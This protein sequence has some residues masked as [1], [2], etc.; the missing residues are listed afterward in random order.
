MERL[1]KVLASAG[2][3][4]RRKAEQMI[5]DGKVS[6]NG[7][8]VREMGFKVSGDDEILVNGKPIR[9][10]EK[11]YYLLNKPKQYISAVTD[12]KGRK[13]VMDC[14]PDVKQ[15]IFPVGRLDYETTGL[16]I[17]T[18]DGEFANVMMHPKYHLPKTYEVAMDGVL[19]DQMIRM[20]EKGI[21]LDDGMTLPAEVYL[22]SRFE[23]KKKTVIQITIHEGRNREIRRMMEYFHCNVTRLN[24]IQY[25]FLD[26]GQLRQGQY[27]KL[28]MYEVKKLMHMTQSAMPAEDNTDSSGSM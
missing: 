6:V 21:P 3:A 8:I 27:R 28:R 18:N 7:T 4:S 10:E 25:G 14:F 16:L 12:D 19:T 13:T 15:R 17:M 9:R 11:V 24:R 26:L 2:V 23:G 1:Q 5:Q 22:L 20:L